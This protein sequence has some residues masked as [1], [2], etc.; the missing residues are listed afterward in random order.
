MNKRSKPLDVLIIEPYHT[1]SH[2]AWADGYKNNSRHNVEVLALEGRYWK[3][4]MHGGAVTLARRFLKE[5]RNPDLILA[6][7]MLDLTTFLALTRPV[8]ASIPTAVYFHENQITY[9]WSP[10]DRDL[11]RGRDGHYGFINFS[12]ALAADRV[13]FNSRYHMGAFLAGLEGFLKGF[14]DYNEVP[15]VEL[16]RHKAAVLHV[17]MDFERLDRISS[18]G[19]RSSNRAPLILWNHRWEYDKNAGEFFKAL[20]ALME[21]GLDFE[22]AVLGE[23]F[24]NKPHEFD[25]ARER[26]GKRVVH[27]GFVEDFASYAGWLKTADIIPVT[28][29]HDFFGCSVIEAVY[30]GAFPLMPNRLAY[31]EHL[32]EELH[33]KYLYEGFDDLVARL[34][35]AVVNIADTRGASLK[36]HVERYGWR[37]LAPIYDV[38]MEETALRAGPVRG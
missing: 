29:T 13:F 26:L 16:I 25:E 36:A 1:G 27:F 19:D 5:G 30:C 17:G 28:S 21:R 8:T 18:Q 7:D 38:E 23:N 35:S 22:V 15:S 9:P 14:P 34:E 3:W 12:S 33:E 2:A 24:K 4:R 37:R 31:P 6:T 11:S 20:Y 10:G 32:P